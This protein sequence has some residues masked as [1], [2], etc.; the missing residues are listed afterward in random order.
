M[1][2]SKPSA[3]QNK[4]SPGTIWPAAYVFLFFSLSGVI[5]RRTLKMPSRTFL[6]GAIGLLIAFAGPGAARRPGSG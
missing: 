6:M 2:E 4:P 5:L 3:P 1:P